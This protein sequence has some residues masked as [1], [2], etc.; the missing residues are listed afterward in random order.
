MQGISNSDQQARRQELFVRLYK[1]AFPVVAKYVSRMGGS[2]D[3]AK[4]IFQDAL[5]VYYEKAIVSPAL[6][7]NDIA[8]LV[9][10]AK[11]LW[12]K[13][14]RQSNQNIPLDLVDVAFADEEHLSNNRLM[15]FLE[16]AGKKCMELL[17]GF[18]YDQLSLTE[19]AN[20][21]GYSGI[22]SATV[23]KYKC[24]EK[25]RETVKEKALTYD[26]FME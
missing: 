7:N 6:L 3:E 15:R 21:F 17:K 10:T 14:Y 12:I 23:Q 11:N 18:Y 5:V 25:V 9:G 22:R 24:L 26:D 1:S 16:T 8:Y 4:D 20:E 2:F 19:I 13:R